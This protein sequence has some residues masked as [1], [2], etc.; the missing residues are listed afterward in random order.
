MH[1]GNMQFKQKPREEQAE[2]DGTEA[3][4]KTAFLL[5]INSTDLLKAFCSP[6]VKVGMT[7]TSSM[8]HND[9]LIQEMS[10]S[11]KDKL[12]I[13]SS[14]LSQLLPRRFTEE[15]STGWLVLSTSSSQQRLRGISLSEFSTLPDSVSSMTHHQ[16]MTHH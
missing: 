6:K 14:M 2:P 4:D 3:A 11:Q 5:G 9:S 1:L 15:C 12:Q 16:S 13:K 8:I 10:T 7:H